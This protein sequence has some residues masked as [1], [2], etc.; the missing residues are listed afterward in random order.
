MFNFFSAQFAKLTVNK[1]LFISVIA[2]LFVPVV[3]GFVHLYF[4][5]GPLDNID[6]LPVAVVN[7][8]QGALQDGEPIHVGN[9]L[10]A[11]LSE[12]KTLGFEFVSTADAM[13]G[14]QNNDYYLVIVL[15][16]DLSQNVTTLMDPDPK[17][18][19]IEYIQNEGLHSVAAQVTNAA[20]STI[21]QQLSKEITKTYATKV[22]TQVGEGLE[23]AAEGSQQLAEGTAQLHDGTTEL[24]SSVT[25]KMADISK[26]AAGTQ[27]LKSG[28]STLLNSLRGSSGDVSK[29]SAGAKDLHA[30]TVT[31]KDGTGQILGGLKDTQAGMQTL[32]TGLS[33]KLGP[34]S[35][36]VADGA[37]QLY[38]GSLE[39]IKGLQDY[40][41]INPTT[42]VGPYNDIIAG[43]KQISEGLAK[44]KTG[45]HQVSDGINNTAAPGAVKLKDGLD[46]L[47]AGQMKINDGAIKLED[48]AKQIADGT[49][50]VNNGWG[51][52]TSGV[53]RLDSGAAQI[54]DGNAQVNEGWKTLASGTTQLNDGAQQVNDGTNQLK[55]GLKAGAENIAPLKNGEE[56]IDMFVAPVELAGKKINSPE[57]YRDTTAP[58]VISL[59]LF[60]GILI[61]SL[62]M[63]FRRPAEVS[64][65]RWFFS[66][67]AKLTSL[68]MVQAA[69]LLLLLFGIAKLH[70]TNP[71]WF[72]L[73]VAAAVSA[74]SAIVLFLSS[75]GGNIGRFFA[76]VLALGQIPLTG[77]DLPIIML[78]DSFHSYSVVLPFTYS[79]EGIR[80]VTLLNHTGQGFYNMAVLLG[81]AIGFSILSFVVYLFKKQKRDAERKPDQRTTIREE[82]SFQF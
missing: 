73:V 76:I 68:G 41:K 43:A 61:M 44:L 6:N 52:L 34:G 57:F 48:G 13:K 71:V 70:M 39:L 28:T 26:L 31:L 75:L 58:Y 49:A 38:A 30:G 14:I 80:T 15:P 74:F 10:I 79:I 3:Y 4:K 53:T 62:F 21:Q 11:K 20:S 65:L 81:F 46:K 50:K 1:A 56:N 63:N 55:D 77:G 67:Y 37:D 82:S 36:S 16:E 23:T 78:P 7:N 47:V 24:N 64:A 19:K 42:W 29:L 51:E 60:V 35:A 69:L 18:L 8:D 32:K 45:A 17:K 66:R 27:E 5:I 25:G 59:A 12:A 72:V 40:Q 2:A 54:A 33:D 9:D 22:V